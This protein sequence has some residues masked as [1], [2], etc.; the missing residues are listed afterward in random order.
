MTEVDDGIP[1]I[2]FTFFREFECNLGLANTT[3]SPEMIFFA[4]PVVGVTTIEI[5][6]QSLHDAFSACE[7]SAGHAPRLGC[8]RFSNNDVF[9]EATCSVGQLYCL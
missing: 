2:T 1:V 5:G 9:V 7:D 4:R 3:H 6:L 8:L